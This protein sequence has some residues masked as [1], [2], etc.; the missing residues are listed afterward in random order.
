MPV[1]TSQIGTESNEVNSIFANK[2][3]GE[4]HLGHLFIISS[5]S[6]FFNKTDFELYLFKK[7]VLGEFSSPDTSV[8]TECALLSTALI[9]AI[10]RSSMPHPSADF[11]YATYE[12]LPSSFQTALLTQSKTK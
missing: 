6:H 11:D 1:V 8:R 12:I 5:S 9:R 3:N 10:F 4:K 7:L 2:G